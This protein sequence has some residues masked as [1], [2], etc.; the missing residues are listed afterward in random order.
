MVG[1]RPI[2][3]PERRARG[4]L[5]ANFRD[6]LDYRQAHARP[7]AAA[8]DVPRSRWGYRVLCSSPG[9]FA[10]LN[11]LDVRLGSLDDR[12]ARFAYCFTTWG[13][14]DRTARTRHS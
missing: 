11:I 7:L 12:F 2:L 9:S 14:S 1:T 6:A 5:V 10:A 13:R 4:N 8:P 3:S